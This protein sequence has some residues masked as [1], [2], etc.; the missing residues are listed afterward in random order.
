MC[1]LLS[2]AG[3]FHKAHDEIFS[4][5]LFGKEKISIWTQCLLKFKVSGLSLALSPLHLGA[6]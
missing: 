6:N 3:G 1:P 4:V 5:D 2:L